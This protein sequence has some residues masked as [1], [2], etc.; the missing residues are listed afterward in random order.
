MRVAIFLLFFG[1]AGAALAQVPEQRLPEKTRILFL[2]DG[3]G[4]MLAQWGS[5][6]RIKA[7]KDLLTDFVDSLK[8]NTNLELALRVYGHQHERYLQRC[9]DSR[10][11]VP[12]AKNNHQQITD[13][14]KVIGPKGV[15]PIAHSLAQAA[16]DFPATGDARNIIIVITDGIES[17]DGDPCAV[18][19][20]LQRKGI[21]LKPFIIGIGMDKQFVDSFG[22]MGRFFDAENIGQFREALNQALNQSLGRTT[23]SVELLDEQGNPTEKDVNLSFLN[24]VTGISAFEFVHY[25]DERGRPDSVVVDPVITYDIVAGTVPPVVLKNVA[26]EAG[27]H[28]VLRMKTPQGT[29]QVAL[30]GH[31]EYPNGVSALI[32]RAGQPEVE[33]VIQLPGEHRLLVGRY[34][35][36]CLTLPRKYFKDVP[37][38]HNQ[39]Q[40]LQLQHPGIVNVETTANGIASLYEIHSDGTQRWVCNLPGG[41]GSHTLTLQPGR[42]KVVY[43]SG[44]AKGSKFTQVKTVEVTSGSSGIVRF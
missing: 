25:R 18:S 40:K 7:A 41:R 3:S 10:L 9:D 31:S 32:R 37:V 19:L 1:Y 43:R 14:L 5:K 24:S 33:T 22:C 35:V 2:L 36:E 15:T 44:K 26:L 34:D 16:G 11:E 29:L 12:F 38:A 6:L 17:C 13:R 28:N 23:V 8:V 4:S 30:P 39:A 42:Y 20:Q 27:R 21:F